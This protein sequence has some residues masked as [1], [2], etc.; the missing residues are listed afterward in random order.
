MNRALIVSPAGET[1]ELIGQ[2]LA[3]EGFS[4]TAHAASGSE[5]RRII[6]RDTEPELIVINAPLSDE[7]GQE[8]AELAA[9]VTSAGLILICGSD[10]ADDVAD[11]V[12]DSGVTVI[13]RPLSRSVLSRTVRV[14]CASR[15]RMMGLKK[16]NDEILTKIDEMRLI[17]RAKSTLMQYL[18]FT[19]PQAHRYIE[20][21]AMN[22]RQ[23]RREVAMRILATYER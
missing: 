3:G 8:L 14:V 17:N 22:T 21:Q 4:K 9:E 18:K 2:V 13:S 10:I 19:E 5:A 12:S 6:G 15:S 20:K 7:F 1:C 23:T 11:K 16:E